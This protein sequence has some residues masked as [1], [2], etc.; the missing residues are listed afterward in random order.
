MI[1]PDLE[2]L[3]FRQ[4]AVPG[5]AF[6]LNDYVAIVSGEHAG[7]FGSVISLLTLDPQPTY[8]VELVEAG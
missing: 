3:W 5:A 6:R 8:L 2:K 4:E 1:S 7:K